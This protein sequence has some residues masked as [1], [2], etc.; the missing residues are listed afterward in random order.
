MRTLVKCV[1]V[2]IFVILSWAVKN[3]W[4]LDYAHMLTL[5]LKPHKSLV[6]EDKSR[7]ESSNI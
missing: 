4:H 2:E 3:S 7:G 6:C 1:R 5:S